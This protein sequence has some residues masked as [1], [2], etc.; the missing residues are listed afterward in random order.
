MNYYCK[1]IGLFIL[2]INTKLV[3]GQTQQVISGTVSDT[4]TGERIPFAVV[5]LKKQLIGT[6]S[7][8]YGAFNFYFPLETVNDSIVVTALGYSSKLFSTQSLLSP[9]IVSLDP[10][11][12]ELS[13]IVVR[14][15]L[16][17]DYIKMAINKVKDNYPHKPFQSQAYYREQ[18]NENHEIINRTEG[19][20]K[21]FYPAYQDTMKNQ[22]QLLLLRKA[23]AKQIAFMREYADKKRA[24]KIRKA[25]RKN[26]DVAKAEAYEGITIKFGGPETI[27]RTDFIKEKEPFL[28]STKFKKFSYSFAGSSTYQ[29][30]ELMVIDFISLKEVDNMMLKGKIYLDVASLAITTITYRAEVDIPTL[31]KPVLFMYGLK[32]IDPVFVKK[33]QYHEV[34]GKWYPKDFQVT[35]SG[36]VTKKH[37]FS[38]NENADFEIEQLFFVNKIET[39]NATPVAAV[40]RYKSKTKMEEQVHN[41]LNLTW[42]E[43]NQVQSTIR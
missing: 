42:S 34:N 37:W 30:K 31:V 5:S 10:R 21:T 2:C 39:E 4:K 22:H 28:D 1:A 36:S 27:L 3:M 11:L 40:K 29:E 12:V 35:G 23:D 33:L 38:A 32:I 26:E 14:A 43:I 7:N 17:T 24:K 16:P 19:V 25:K 18:V 13:T 9:L 15:L 20:F 8:E 41:E 6:N